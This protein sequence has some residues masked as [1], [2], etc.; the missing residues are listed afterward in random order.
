MASSCSSDLTP[1][2]GTSPYAASVAL[3]PT[4][5]PTTQKKNKKLQ[6][7][8]LEEGTLWYT[9]KLESQKTAADKSQASEQSSLHKAWPPLSTP[10][11]ASSTR[12]F[13][14]GIF[15][16]QAEIGYN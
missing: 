4:T 10:T 12:I 1:S 11:N 8:S 5:T 7:E 6:S 14:P 15:S 2:L 13:Q 3:N 9:V 16:N